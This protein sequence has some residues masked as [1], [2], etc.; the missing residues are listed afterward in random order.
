MEQAPNTRKDLTLFATGLQA[1]LVSEIRPALVALSFAVVFLVLV[2]TVNLAS[3]LLA[4]A[5]EREL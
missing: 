3:L 5:A 2:L 1:D 4:R